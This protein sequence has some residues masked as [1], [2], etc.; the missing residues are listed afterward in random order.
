MKYE[1]CA[2]RDTPN[3]CTVVHQRVFKTHLIGCW[4]YL[5][6]VCFWQPLG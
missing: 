6:A 3:T 1:A 5:G 2:I 4:Q